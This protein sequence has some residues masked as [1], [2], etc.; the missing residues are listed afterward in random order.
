MTEERAHRPKAQ[1]KNKAATCCCHRARSGL[2][3]PRVSQQSGQ[4]KNGRRAI[5]RAPIH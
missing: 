4:L 2:N 1:W 3:H 5:L